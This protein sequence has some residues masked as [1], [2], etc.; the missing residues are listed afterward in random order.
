MDSV[1]PHQGIWDDP[2]HILITTI[3]STRTKDEVT[4]RISLKLFCKYPDP[5]SLAYA[6]LQDL[7]NTIRGV[8]F[9]RQKASSIKNTARIIMEKYHGK[10]PNDKEKLLELPGVGTKVAN[11]VLTFGYGK[12]YIAVDTHVHR[13]FN[14]IGIVKTKSPEKTEKEL[15][16]KLPR[17]YWKVVN[18]YGVE[19]GKTICKPIKPK[20]EICQLRKVCN[21]YEIHS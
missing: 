4:D 20:C 21:Y 18:A 19:F 10:V 2:Y 8:G 17:K 13:I 5:Q 14:R 9:Y 1:S 3:L 11:I 12:D 6:N 7:T 15:E 16:L